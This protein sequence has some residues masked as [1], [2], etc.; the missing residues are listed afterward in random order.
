[1]TLERHQ[2]SNE[3][4]VFDLETERRVIA[5]RAAYLE[6]GR[7]MQPICVEEANLQKAWN[8]VK[9]EG[10]IGIVGDARDI[11]ETANL[12]RTFQEEG[13]FASIA[14]TAWNEEAAKIGELSIR[15]MLREEAGT[16]ADELEADLTEFAP[17]LMDEIQTTKQF[18]Q[19]TRTAA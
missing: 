19:L 14:Y 18:L 4:F 11:I 7:R 15:D 8:L 16:M 10:A 12:L 2:G 1:M 3:E 17:E 13:E 5:F 9:P 6:C